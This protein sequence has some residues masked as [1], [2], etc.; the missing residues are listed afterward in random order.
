MKQ[1]G[2]GKGEGKEEEDGGWNGRGKT[3][4]QVP[5]PRQEDVPF[6]VWGEKKKILLG[7]QYLVPYLHVH[8]D[9]YCM[10]PWEGW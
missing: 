3:L 5:R 4:R 9:V 6:P 7:M 10:H 1:S 2:R 8:V